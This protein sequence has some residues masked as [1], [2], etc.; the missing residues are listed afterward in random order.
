MKVTLD[1]TK[2][3]EEWKITKEEF[4]K[5]SSFSS[6]QT[7]LMLINILIAFSVIA[8][9]VWLFILVPEVEFALFISLIIT[10]LWFVFRNKFFENWCILANIFILL[11]S[12]WIAVS[13]LWVLEKNLE[14]SKFSITFVF[15]SI[16]VFFA[17]MSYFARSNFL[18][19]LS[20]LTISSILWAGTDYFHASYYF[21][22]EYP[23]LTIWIYWLLAWITYFLSKR[24][25]YE[26]ERLLIVFSRTS[27]FMVNMAFWVGSLWW[28]RYFRESNYSYYSFSQTSE[29][30]TFLQKITSPESFSI[31]WAILII[32]AIVWWVKN[33]K[34]FIVNT[35]ATF[36]A[37][38]FYTQYFE[39]LWWEPIFL[40]LAWVIWI[41]FAVILWKYNKKFSENKS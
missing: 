23:T 30:L 1:I 27:F 40:I 22:V 29:K 36:W 4:D 6:H 17:I 34:R 11:W 13:Y 15:L 12:I 2:L 38:H 14:A 20:A 35:A 39:Y 16:S 21:F 28:D 31:F 19:W 18:A 33:N 5:I 7:W 8:I 32:F 9:S 3:L 41:I 10:I 37:I 25:S 26:I 24:F